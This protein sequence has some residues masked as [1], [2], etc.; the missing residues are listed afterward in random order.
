MVGQEGHPPVG[1]GHMGNDNVTV[2]GMH[3]WDMLFR[4]VQIVQISSTMGSIGSLQNIL[5]TGSGRYSAAARFALPYRCSKA[6]LN[7]GM[8]LPQPCLPKAPPVLMVSPPQHCTIHGA[9][10]PF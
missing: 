6:A 8:Q 9:E 5:R 7:M 3:K 2:A 1:L 4:H 10:V